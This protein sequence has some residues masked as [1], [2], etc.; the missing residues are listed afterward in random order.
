[1]SEELSKNEK[2]SKRLKEIYA[3][4]DEQRKNIVIH[5]E[6]DKGEGIIKDIEIGVVK[7]FVKEE[8]RGKWKGSIE[9]QCLEMHIETP[10]KTIIKQI[11]TF[12]PHP[13][14]NMGRWRRRYE[15]C[16]DINDKVQLRHDGN[17]W[18][19]N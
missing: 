4:L 10:D 9:A 16:P 5:E 14:S 19:L 2:T 11:M 17:F 13:N 15:K 8:D 6:G 18:R 12:S 3:K 7:D 1:M